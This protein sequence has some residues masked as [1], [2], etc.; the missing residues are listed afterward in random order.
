MLRE[1]FSEV[2]L[3]QKIERGYTYKYISEESGVPITTVRYALNGGTNVGISVF[4]VLLDFFEVKVTFEV[5]D[6]VYF[7]T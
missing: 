6:S 3:S 4:E 2:L 1:R 7:L 5:D